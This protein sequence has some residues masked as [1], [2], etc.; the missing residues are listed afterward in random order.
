MQLLL[1]GLMDIQVHLPKTG[2]M[3][4]EVH[5]MAKRS[6]NLDYGLAGLRERVLLKHVMN[7]EMHTRGVLLE[8]VRRAG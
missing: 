7:N 5:L 2:L 6:K 3:W 8:S 4:G 1:D